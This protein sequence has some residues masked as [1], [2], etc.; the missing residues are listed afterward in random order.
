PILRCY[1][2]VNRRRIR[3]SAGALKVKGRASKSVG[4]ERQRAVSSP[5]RYYVYVSLLKREATVHHVECIF[6]RRRAT[7]RTPTGFWT[8]FDDHEAAMDFAQLHARGGMQ[9][10]PST[11]QVRWSEARDCKN[12]HAARL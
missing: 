10:M 2:W 4:K 3:Q 9:G 11:K 6:A 5:H 8:G 12:C 1:D 7:G